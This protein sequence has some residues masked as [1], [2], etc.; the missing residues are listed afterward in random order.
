MAPHLLTS[1]WSSEART[2]LISWQQRVLCPGFK[3][4]LVIS[5]HWDT[6]VPTVSVV[7]GNNHTVHYFYGLPENMY[8]FMDQDSVCKINSQQ[9]TW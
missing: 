5:G 1:L 4:V 7:K 6:K 2:F 8:K 9:H 3:A